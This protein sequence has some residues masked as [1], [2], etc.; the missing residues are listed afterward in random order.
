MADLDNLVDWGFNSIRLGVMWPGVEPI[1]GEYNDTY[2]QIIDEIVENAAKKG[3][4]TLLD[5]HQDV[6]SPKLCGEGIPLWATYNDSE[7]WQFP[8]PVQWTAFEEKNGLPKDEDCQQYG[9][10]TFYMAEAT[11]RAF[12][13]LYDNVGGLRDALGRY[14][15]KIAKQFNGREHVLGY[16]LINEPWAGNHISNP[17]RLVPGYADRYNLGPFYDELTRYIRE[18]DKE[19]FI[20]FESV[21]WDDFLPLGFTH[22]PG[23]PENANKS[24]IS[25]HY[26]KEVNFNL[27]WQISARE[28]DGERL[29]TGLLCTEFDIYIY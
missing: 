19:G 22:P 2:L 13:N 24:I 16:E 25:Y 26:Y 14:W 28:K 4:Y 1:R 8:R 7:A 3:V 20:F 27:D 23:G 15:Q 12:Q 11:G 6:Y 10:A 29:G 18:V 21:T 5:F 17:L 9:W